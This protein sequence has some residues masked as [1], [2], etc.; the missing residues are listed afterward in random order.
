MGSPIQRELAKRELAQ[1]HLTDFCTY[2]DPNVAHT[3]NLPHLRLMA[4]YLTR[5]ESGELWHNLPGAGKKILIIHTPPRHWKT[6]LISHKFAAWFVGKRKTEGNPHELILTSYAA[7]LAERNSRAVIDIIRD[8][9]F[10]QNIFPTI[11]LSKHSQAAEE[12]SLADSATT[13]CKAAG[14]GG[15]LTGYGGVVII[16]DPIKDRQQAN[17]ITYLNL[18]WD[19]WADVARTRINPD[20]FAIICA[21]RWSADDLVGRLLR[22]AAISGERIVHLRL[23]ALA[24]TPH[25][26]L[27]AA[28]QGLPY[29]AHDPLGRQPGE[30]LAESIVSRAE[31][32][33]TKLLYPATHA[34]LNQG[35]PTPSEGYLVSGEKFL[36]LT[37]IPTTHIRWVI[38]TDWAITSR[39][40]APKS[41]PDPDYTVATLMGMW[42]PN[43]PDDVRLVLAR[44]WRGQL[45]PAQAKIKM[46]AWAK[47]ADALIGGPPIPI[48]SSQTMA[49]KIYLS[50]LRASAD[51]I[52]RAITILPHQRMSGDKVTNATSW[53]EL[54]HAGRFY[55]VQDPHR[56]NDNWTEE[57]KQ[58]INSF[59][60]GPFDDICD[61]ISAG[62]AALHT[63]PGQ[64]L[65]T[66]YV[67][68]Y[69]D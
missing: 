29:D 63:I 11:R 37:T 1:R 43:G 27:A 66:S 8:N 36:P 62:T 25:E 55:I 49:D 54:L 58:E 57:V 52:G 56:A 20:Q 18:L 24:E 2:I 9:E 46:K 15:G 65:T 38:G 51:Q 44:M 16:D 68:F 61:S 50:D 45:D 32:R 31:H 48:V 33:I 17:S 60:H 40:M 64:Q 28:K 3:Y 10:Y 39:Q 34:T 26:R 42:T 59:P 41:R 69:Q 30:A 14:V 67:S 23:P 53:I 22:T 47:L 21:T 12:W 13:T 35:C 4:D 19:W 5:A 7:S 6:S